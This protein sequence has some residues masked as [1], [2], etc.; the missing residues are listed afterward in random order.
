[1]IYKEY[2]FKYAQLKYLLSKADD[3]RVRDLIREKY[4]PYLKEDNHP[5][6]MLWAI[7][8]LE[9]FKWK[10]QYRH[11]QFDKLE[12]KLLHDDEEDN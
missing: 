10:A 7:E 3:V 12:D 9:D 4:L 8:A 1:M 5:D 6:I 11:D 2:D